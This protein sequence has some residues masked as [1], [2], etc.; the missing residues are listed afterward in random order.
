MHFLYE[1][2]DH[3]NSDWSTVMKAVS[4]KEYALCP[5]NSLHSFIPKDQSIAILGLRMLLFS[6]HWIN[7]LAHLNLTVG[8]TFPRHRELQ[9]IQ[10]PNSETHRFAVRLGII[11]PAS[12]LQLVSPSSKNQL[13]WVRPL[14]FN[15][16]S[17][18]K[19]HISKEIQ[20]DAGNVSDGMLDLSKD[21]KLKKGKTAKEKKSKGKKQSKGIQKSRAKVRDK[22][23]R[24]NKRKMTEDPDVWQEYTN[25]RFTHLMGNFNAI[26]LLKPVMK[27]LGS[28]C[29]DAFAIDG[30][31]PL[32]QKE[33]FGLLLLFGRQIANPR[34]R[35][36]ASDPKFLQQSLSQM[37]TIA[38]GVIETS[39]LQALE[40]HRDEV[41]AGIFGD[42]EHFTSTEALEF[43][44]SN[45]FNKWN[46][47]L[48]QYNEKNM[49]HGNKYFF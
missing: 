34:I 47:G 49:S 2:C 46:I 38:A 23:E 9:F 5:A 29:G 14:P 31:T 7:A 44:Y 43:A 8:M 4:P 17:N 16:G 18:D 39:S 11:E 10:V 33:A 36:A 13:I 24:G 35:A 30:V 15:S 22:I 41:N 40:S 45:L 21:S 1:N 12:D 28:L 20:D 6:K 26:Q 3:L 37:D 48:D 42:H 27:N 25:P 32:D 19:S